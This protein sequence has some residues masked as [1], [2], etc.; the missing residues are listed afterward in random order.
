MKAFPFEAPQRNAKIFIL[1]QL[2]ELHGAGRVAIL[3]NAQSNP[4]ANMATNRN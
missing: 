4:A 3:L 2:S 1:I